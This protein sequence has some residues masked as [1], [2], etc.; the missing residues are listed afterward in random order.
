MGLRD[1]RHDRQDARRTGAGPVRYQMRE[2]L[3]SIGDDYWIEDDNGDKVFRVDGKALR[4][5][6]TLDFE[7]AQGNKL[8]RI[9]T[10]VMHIRD[11]M[12]IEDPE[13]DRIAL[14]HKALITP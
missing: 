11:T 9:Q 12:E 2:R 5:R 14:V 13:G 8:C 3:V 7:D 6:K 10:R 4:M 1:S